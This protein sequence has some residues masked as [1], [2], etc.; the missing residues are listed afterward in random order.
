MMTIF[1]CIY[2]V[3]HVSCQLTRIALLCLHILLLYAT[4]QCA[5]HNNN[6]THSIHKRIMFIAD[7]ARIHMAILAFLAVGL[8]ASISWFEKAWNDVQRSRSE[9]GA[10]ATSSTV[11]SAGGKE[12]K[13]D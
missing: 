13:T 4:T 9:G 6:H 5:L 12:E 11:S 8:L 10:S 7:I 2:T 1:E 3:A